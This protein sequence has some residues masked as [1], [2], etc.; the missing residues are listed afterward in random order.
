MQDDEIED[1]RQGH[2]M[3]GEDDNDAND[4]DDMDGEQDDG[5]IHNQLHPDLLAAAHKMGLNI[6][7]EQI[8][9]IQKFIEQQNLELNED[10][11][12][13]DGD[14]EGDSMQ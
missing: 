9:E 4:E 7:S 6:D 10:G 13:S 14:M 3:Q 2:L 11:E 1:H 5:D 12:D 8:H